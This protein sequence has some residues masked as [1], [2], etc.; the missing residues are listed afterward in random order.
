M[1]I[2]CKKCTNSGC[3]SLVIEVNKTEYNNL[4]GVVK[5]EFVKRSDVFIK[6]NPKYKSKQDYLDKM[7]VD[8][9]ATMNKNKDGLCTLLD[10]N[11]MLCTE[12]ENRPK[13]CQDYNTNRCEKIRE[14]EI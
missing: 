11:T 3:C 8:N 12:Y 10:T 1:G 7:Y 5:N 14:Y 9:F 6:L 2:D 4:K 13:V